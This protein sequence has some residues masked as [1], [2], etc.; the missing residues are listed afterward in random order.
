MSV[1]ANPPYIRA[2]EAATIQARDEAQEAEAVCLQ[3]V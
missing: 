1:N 3:R 2:G